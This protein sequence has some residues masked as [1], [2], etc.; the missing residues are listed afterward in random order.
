MSR[1]RSYNLN[2][3]CVRRRASKDAFETASTLVSSLPHE[4]PLRVSFAVS[5][6][7]RAARIVGNQT[8]RHSR[9]YGLG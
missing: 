6:K 1:G 3:R 5:W 2:F 4:A 8:K 9:T 7:D